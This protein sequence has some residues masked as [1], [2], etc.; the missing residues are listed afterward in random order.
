MGPPASLTVRHP[1]PTR[2]PVSFITYALSGHEL[3]PPTIF[4]ALAA[5]NNIRAPLFILPL[6]FQLLSDA[7]VAL[8]RLSK[9]MLTQEIDHPVSVI[10]NALYAISTHHTDYSWEI[11]PVASSIQPAGSFLHTR[12]DLSSPL[13]QPVPLRPS[14]LPNTLLPTP[15][16]PVLP[17]PSPAQIPL[18]PRRTQPPSLLL[19]IHRL[20]LP[21]QTTPTR[22]YPCKRIARRRYTHTARS[23]R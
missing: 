6:A 10:P 3:S 2:P 11:Y 23:P 1:A 19:Q 14:E 12:R 16:I 7:Y 17:S 21:L 5:F 8:V 13:N 4:A 15:H 20:P 18:H 22:P 9:L